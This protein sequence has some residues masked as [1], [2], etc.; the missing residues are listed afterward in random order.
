[1][2]QNLFFFFFGVICLRPI[3]FYN[4]YVTKKV[5]NH[6]KITIQPLLDGPFLMVKLF[7]LKPLLSNF[8]TSSFQN[9]QQTTYFESP[10]KND[11]LQ[12]I[13]QGQFYCN[14]QEMEAAI[15]S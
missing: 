2:S 10:I 3:R 14:S 11:I 13:T 4:F 7:L 5:T 9:Q 15:S 6:E 1:M 8:T 12:I